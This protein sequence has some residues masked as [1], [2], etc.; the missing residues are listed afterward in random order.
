MTSPVEP[1]PADTALPEHPDSHYLH[2]K[3][4]V[5]QWLGNASVSRRRAFA[6]TEPKLPARLNT[7]TADQHAELN[8]LNAAHWGVQNTIDR[9][10][11]RVRDA[12]AFAEPLLKNA[13]KTR[14]GLDLDVKKTFLRLHI[15]LTIP[16]FPVKSG[17]SRTWTI[18]LLDAA[19]HNFESKETQADHFEADSTFTT[20]PS[21]TG[22]F[23]TLPAVKARI[24]IPAF[25]QLC[26]DLDIGGQYKTYL[27]ENLG[28]TNPVVA[29]VLKPKVV[30]SQKAAL[31]SALQFARM[32]RDIQ[33]DYFL[34]IQGML[35]G[36]QGMRLAGEALHCHDLT[37][38]SATLT[39]I[40]LFAPDLERA[41]RTVRV[42][43]YIP[44][45]PRHPIKEYPSTLEFMQTLT[46][47]L[48]D[49]D[50]QKFF[51][52]FVA[53]EE[54]GYFFGNLANRL[55]SITWHQH[56][57][58]DSRPT[59][60]ETPIEQP[61]LQFASTPIKR[62]LWQHLYQAK[63][64][65]ILNDGR[66]IAV[67]TA[68]ADQKAR[69]ALWDSFVDIA[70]TIL[71]VAVFVV[72][73]F[74]PLAGEMMMAYMAYQLLD[75]T[76]ESIV[77]WAEGL[78]TEAFEHFLGVVESLIQLG[79][80]AVGGTV[81]ASE[82]RKVLPREVVRFID[83][84]KPVSAHGGKT[85]Y[86]Q[87]DLS[88][89]ESNI[90]PP[91]GAT[92]DSLGL[93]QLQ[94]K[95][96]VKIEDKH[97]AV[98]AT[99][100]TYTVQHPNRPTAYRPA[101][102]HNGSG[103]WK[104]ELDQP[105]HWDNARM[106]R[107]LG[108]KVDDFTDLELDH[109]LRISNTDET[110]LRKM[111]V[112]SEAE[113]P[114]LTDTLERLRIEKDIKQLI[115]QLRSDDPLEYRQ[116]DPQAQLQLLTSYGLWPESRA[117][118]FLDAEG[119]TAWEFRTK[120]HLPV[121]QIHEAQLGN[122][123]L[124][125]TVL[126]TLDPTDIRTL[127]GRDYDNPAI[128]I[129]TR[130]RNLARKLAQIAEDKRASLFT[131][132]YTEQESTPQP[133]PRKIIEAVPGLP[134]SV[135]QELLNHASGNELREIDQGHLPKRLEDLARQANEEVRVTR[136]YE[137]LYLD[138]PA[139]PDTETLA[140]R[141][142]QQLPGWSTEVRID[143][144]YNAFNGP[145][146]DGIGE[147]QAPIHKILVLTSDGRY[148]AY[149]DQGLELSGA[150]DLYSA[151]LQALPDTQR[152]S[153]NMHIGE[154]G[155]LKQALR[156]NPLERAELRTALA[157]PPAPQPV[158]E[159]LR[160]LGVEGYHR[161]YSERPRTLEDRAREIYPGL[162]PQRIQA[163][164]QRLQNH[165]SGPR[166]E[167]SR[168]RNEYLQLQDDLYIWSN[169]PPAVHPRTNVALSEEELLSET[170]NRR[171]LREQLLRC[172][173]QETE[174]LYPD[175]GA[176]G[177]HTF[178]FSLPITGDLPTLTADFS[179]VSALSLVNGTSARGIDTFLQ[180]FPGLRRLELRDFTLQNLPQP[181]N[182]LPQ[183]NHLILNNCALTLTPQSQASISSLTRLTKLDLRNNPLGRLPSLE[184]MPDLMYVDL[185]G[186]GITSV[187]EGL[188]NHPVIQFANL[189]GNRI[190]E[191]PVALFDHPEDVRYGFDFGNNPLSTV[192]RERIK[193]YFKQ[194]EWDFEVPADQSDIDRVKALY[195]NL[196]D[197][198]AS[199]FVYQLPGTLIEGRAYLALRE[200]ELIRLTSELS[201][202]AAN[203]PATHPATGT[204]LTADEM[205]AE[206]VR[207]DEFK[208]NLER[209]WRQIPI[210]NAATSEYGFVSH[211]SIMG[212]LPTL[213][214]DFGH[215]PEL[216]LTSTGGNLPRL[217]S[218][219]ENFANLESLTIRGYQLGNLP[220][221]V[222]RMNRLT[223]LSL[224]DCA[225]TLT[226]GTAEALAGM[227][228]LD[229]LNLRRNPLG[230]SPDLRQMND[231]SSLDLSYTGISEIPRGLFQINTW[232]DVDLS[233]NAITE[234]PIELM[235]VDA[236]VGESFDFSSNPFTDESLQRIA[237][238]YRATENDLGINEVAN[239][240][241]PE[242][243][244][245]NIDIED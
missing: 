29:A 56:T 226:P 184:S 212:D 94:D 97:Y 93:Y 181:I 61:N 141:S 76:F 152:N 64:N 224:P 140:L 237:A 28:V 68:T 190:T 1:Q 62:P 70:K 83:R 44:D 238:Y 231:I 100:D 60:R 108:H 122:G 186:T 39:G 178:K 170:Q 41:R 137:G 244:A 113:P 206:H 21:P 87:P 67:S 189:N 162:S 216:Y 20:Q 95:R 84:F 55:S 116:A 225:I 31:K 234:M 163:L 119:K 24:S 47:Q 120:E 179:H 72:A 131:S 148:Q 174:F 230:L 90:H 3:N 176:T 89:Y 201:L 74:V 147:P 85:R 32:N 134:K 66:V 37:M 107:R 210:E 127:Y 18:S 223:V 168:L 26:R 33:E 109:A 82:F 211:L 77:D 236:G 103:A 218:F 158:I 52:R 243:E 50:Y 204:A 36:I 38:M 194:T 241:I 14:Y 175:L 27:E 88:N 46:G 221:A 57:P 159:N 15:P 65:K 35:D 45:D 86:W 34:L 183:L 53:H 139:S 245:P 123:N 142:L 16:W 200:A 17:G 145:R 5:P 71:E 165:P 185:A 153:L 177:G 229:F 199:I 19:L 30:E 48:R 114:L 75:E 79:G 240:P 164:L 195:P 63:L 126:E 192:T 110:V 187:P 235:E 51:S 40:V 13:I 220:E 118:R 12:N 193:A 91:E 105:L 167:L 203:V 4:A 227:D 205:F 104:T 228:R 10:L 58:G 196:E 150:T 130:A 125:R 92:P 25:T 209:C 202:W 73:P 197:E 59:W 182:A 121:I 233:H 43:A 136:A 222:F 78:K 112:H 124:L 242:D 219:L 22:Q 101:L 143:V 117:L 154:N 128:P 157:L 69:W 7:A 214:A 155:K 169:N 106:A 2:L 208:Q 42:V 129:D 149:D 180:Q 191:L 198:T 98:Q 8:A 102:Q 160:L 144:H 146:V 133:R 207:R 215:V 173:R 156:D 171:L 232:T 81:V 132:R 111:H 213:S 115:A 135:A 54:R 161:S 49:T 239:M 6:G 9:A 96:I 11:E 217:G 172:W 188:V 151:V 99:G 23:E 80:F 166:A 138:T